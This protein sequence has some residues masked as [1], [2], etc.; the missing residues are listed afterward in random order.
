MKKLTVLITAL[1]VTCFSG[2]RAYAAVGDVINLQLGSSFSFYDLGGAIDST[3][4][5]TW[6][7]IVSSGSNSFGELQLSGG[8]GSGVSLDYYYMDGS[9]NTVTTSFTDLNNQPLMVG[10]LS[11][12]DL[13][14]GTFQFSGLA[15]GKYKIY[16]YSQ[17]DS[18]TPSTLDVTPITS[19]STYSKISFANAGN[20]TGFTNATNTGFGN[21]AV[22]TVDVG[23]AIGPDYGSANL[24][25]NVSTLSS[26]N[27]IQIQAVPE[28]GSVVLLGLGGVFMLGIIRL[29]SKDEAELNV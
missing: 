26:I 18:G 4:G 23:N 27:G 28:P 19:V 17:I 21:W 9:S 12:G 13:S 1:A 5:Q 6:N 25:L 11:N 8:M 16:V 22:K 2:G 24:V 10:F 14:T 29:R 20:Y 15:A 7:Q 3:P